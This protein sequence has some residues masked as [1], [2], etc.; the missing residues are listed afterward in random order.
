MPRIL[1]VDDSATMIMNLSH[2]LR[3][4][5]Y[6]VETALDGREGITKLMGGARFS[7]ILT[8][9]NMPEL[10]G[11]EFIQEARKLA[12]TR[13]TPIV[14]LTTETGGRKRDAAR[15]AGASGWLTK[16]AA[17]NQL[18]AV[19]RQLCRADKTGPFPAGAPHAMN[20]NTPH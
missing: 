6:D 13:F 2:I 5:G 1:V 16:P 4:A 18:L 19:L 17:P 9:L 8:D 7:L 10:D 20:G 15:A 11:I 3:D 14:V 12:P